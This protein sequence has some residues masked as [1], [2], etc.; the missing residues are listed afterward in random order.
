[1]CTLLDF[2]TSFFF[3]QVCEECEEKETFIRSWWECK[4]VQQLGRTDGEVPQKL[5]TTLPYDPA[6][7]FLA[8]SYKEMKSNWAWCYMPVIPA[9]GR[10]RQEDHSLDTIVTSYLAWVTRALLKYNL[11]II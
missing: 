1:V 11:C 4:L 2:W 6:I 8:I 10:M 3:F 9:L 5:K 7:P